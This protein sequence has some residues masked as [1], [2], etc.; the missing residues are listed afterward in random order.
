MS[1]WEILCPFNPTD[2]LENQDL[3]IQKNTW[4]Y[5]HFT[6]LH[7]KWQSYNVSFLRHKARQT[8]FLSFWIVF[9]SLPYEPRKSK[10]W[11]N[12]KT[13]RR[14]Y[15]FTHVYRNW[16]SY[17]VWYLRYRVR[18]TIFFVI[19]DHFLPFYPPNN[20]KNQNLIKI[21][22]KKNTWRYHHFKIVPQKSWSSAILFLRYGAW[23]M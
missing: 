17:D 9:C 10:F 8:I 3:N 14:Y 13:T 16:Q 23:W 15:H 7:H 19:L 4:T 2:N 20:P 12:E 11:K 5:Y 22:I 1:F 21:I 6:N 18:Q